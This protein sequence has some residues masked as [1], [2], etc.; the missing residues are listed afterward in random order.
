MSTQHYL[1]GLK[2]VSRGLGRLLRRALPGGKPD[3]AA[4]AGPN[5][6]GS[7]GRE[8]AA[9]AAW[10][11]SASYGQPSSWMVGARP[12]AESA[13]LELFMGAF[14][15]RFAAC[16]RFFSGFFKNVP[17]IVR[18]GLFF[19]GEHIKMTIAKIIKQISSMQLMTSILK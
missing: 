3:V 15:R 2:R 12:F 6:L 8:F 16:E 14:R 17:I 11:I 5:L 4:N 10:Q 7:P 19:Y 13:C 18:L 9:S 1:K